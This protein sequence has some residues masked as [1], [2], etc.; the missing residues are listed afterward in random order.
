M[1]AI[2]GCGPLLYEIAMREL[3]S[4]S[5]D[6]TSV[7]SSASNVWRVFSQRDDIERTALRRRHTDNW[8]NYSYS[9]LAPPSPDELDTLS[10]MRDRGTLAMSRLGDGV[11]D[12][13]KAATEMQWRAIC[14]SP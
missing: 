10:Q 9:M 5:P 13:V 3:G 14:G 11:R 7:T 8:L 1:A 6:L 12:M 2:R 4:L